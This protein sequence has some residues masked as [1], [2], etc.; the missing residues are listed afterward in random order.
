MFNL[1]DNE[2]SIL[3][4]LFEKREEN[5]CVTTEQDKKN[6]R[7]LVEENDTYEMLLTKIS[8][9]CNNETTRDKVEESLESYIDRVNVIGSYENEKFYKTRFFR[10]YKSNI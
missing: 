7:K 5:I 1:N 4:E 6:I 8:E 10:C 3:N 9:L 2:E